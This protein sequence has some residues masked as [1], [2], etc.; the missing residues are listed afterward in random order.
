MSRPDNQLASQAQLT[1]LANRMGGR[2]PVRV[3]FLN[4][5]SKVFLA[6]EG[7]R[8]KDLVRMVVDKLE[9][10]DPDDV[11]GYFALYESLN[12]SSI[13]DA[14]HMDALIVDVINRWGSNKDAKL[15]FMIRIFVKSVTGLET[16][17]LCARRLGKDVRTFLHEDYLS[18]AHT[19]DNN[20]LVLQHMQ[21]VY[22]VI[23]GKYPVSE[24]DAIR[25]GAIHFLFKFKEFNPE[26]HV[27]GFLGNRIVEFIPTLMLRAKRKVRHMR[28]ILTRLVC[29]V[30][31]DPSSA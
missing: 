25:L 31:R 12:G 15:V 4:N 1:Q 19:Y 23:T 13:G 6:K 14:C 22:N 30:F 8:V 3:F 17:E 24:E 2:I 10:K 20:C 18:R 9:L 16:V 29:C 5:S 28:R 7:T 26:Q 21:A 27:I 11:A